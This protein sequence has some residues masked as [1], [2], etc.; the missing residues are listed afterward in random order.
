MSRQN[1]HGLQGLST[2]VGAYVVSYPT[3]HADFGGRFPH[4]DSGA[5]FTAELALGDISK[6]FPESVALSSA[7]EEEEGP[8]SQSGYVIN[9]AHPP[10]VG[11]QQGGQK[12][13]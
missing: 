4:E 9:V 6:M 13:F 7:T 5:S 2:R 12:G 3:H 8:T 11:P 1:Y 10:S